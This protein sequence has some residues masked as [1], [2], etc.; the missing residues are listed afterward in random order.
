MERCN[1]HERTE[2]ILD[3]ARTYQYWLPSSSG[4]KEVHRTDSNSLVIIG[5]NGSG[6]SKLG[7]WIESKDF[8]SVHRIAAQ[9]SLNF[10][11]RI[12]QKSFQEA[13][14]N[15]F[16]GAT[17]EVWK[18]EKR[19]KWGHGKELTTTLL[20]DF[21][22]VL[23]AVIAQVNNEDHTYTEA[24][25]EAERRG[26]EKPPTRPTVL[27]KL[28]AIW[29]E[30]I[31]HRHINMEDGSFYATDLEKDSAPYSA[32]QMSDGERSVLYLAAQILCL[33]E[34]T[35]V[36]ID[37]PE[38]HLHPSL[39]HRFWR[40]IEKAREDCL[41]IYITHDVQFAALHGSG[42]VVWVKSYDG[43]NWNYELL[44]EETLPDSLLLELMGNRK[45]VLFVEG[46]GSS[47]DARLYTALF[48]EHYIVPRG[49]CEQVIESTKT[50]RQ[51][52]G[53][54]TYCVNGLIDRD[55][56]SVEAMEALKNKG[57]LCLQ[58]AEIENLF[59]TEDVVREMSSLHRRNPE[60]D[61]EEVAKYVVSERFANEMEMQIMNAL[62]Y[63]I[64][65]KLRDLDL[66]DGSKKN[67]AE[68]FQQ[69]I[70][71]IDCVKIRNEIEDHFSTVLK[72]GQ[73]NKILE[74]FNSKGLCSSIGHYMG[75]EDKAYV[76]TVIRL[77]EKEP[78]GA[79][80]AAIKKHIPTVSD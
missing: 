9:R 63:E 40:E 15:Y 52:L 21:D 75:Y 11:E 60:N 16:Y 66:L 35:I 78:D 53:M 50:Y 80:A 4:A 24:C 55:Y 39:M 33:K 7:A 30:L 51:T 29:D 48:P 45:N 12:P 26:I 5:A 64:K 1:R 69:I 3:N 14:D 31:P 58:V 43:N 28:I 42:G 72:E 36:I 76:P 74:V 37:E 62:K 19:H 49:G 57:V 2:L 47:V 65:S 17:A 77:V 54:H 13:Q 44:S 71:S 20:Q 27:N 70:H 32:T 41:F 34:N 18:N 73:L 67:S 38:L 61:L 25:R 6:K 8:E 79:V 46:S 56:R 23:A 22:D 59:V 68:E 10:S